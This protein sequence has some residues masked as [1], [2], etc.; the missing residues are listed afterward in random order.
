MTFATSLAFLC[1]ILSLGF[2]YGQ[3]LADHDP[4]FKFPAWFW[5][6]AGKGAIA[7]VCIWIFL[8]LGVFTSMPPL[9]P[10]LERAR[11]AG[12]WFPLFLQEIG[13]GLEVIGSYWGAI[14]F[15]WFAVIIARQSPDRGDF[16][17]LAVVFAA[18]L[19]PLAGLCLYLGGAPWTG[20]ALL[21][22]L[23]PL[24]HCGLWFLPARRRRP[25]YSKAV[26]KMKFGKYQEAEWEVIRELEQE[27]E[28][29][30]GWLMLA[31]LYANHFHDLQGARQTI[32]DLAEQPGITPMQL[33]IACHRLAEWHLKLAGDPVAARD[34]LEEVCRKFPDSHAARMTRLRIAQL[35]G[36][37][38]EW[39]AQRAG[40][41]IA[42]P[43]AG[44]AVE[45]A[46]DKS[47]SEMSAEQAAAAAERCVEKLRNDPNDVAEREKLAW[48]YAEA[49]GQPRL[50]IEQLELLIAMPEQDPV[51]IPPWLSLMAAWQLKFLS[52]DDAAR[53]IFE[54]LISEYPQSRDA[55]TAQRRLNLM[56]VEARLRRRS[57]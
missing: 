27:E 16:A 9:L 49:L 34:A 42:L 32:R 29:F 36:S 38:A 18:L 31:E 24:T 57:A 56:N 21:L 44:D 7:P 50:G 47:I 46:G 3:R 2:Y 41:K 30:D 26:A 6:W 17:A 12:N 53:A 39:E 13:L 35:P 25:A 14:T 45:A 37:K 40:K 1:G 33:S 48:L 22:C 11:S 23:L 15:G 5:H 19:L 52:D 55:F 51:K 54:R 4:A 8:N 20:F 43:P 28:N 10:Q